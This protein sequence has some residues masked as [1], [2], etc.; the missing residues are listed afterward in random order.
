MS[1][2]ILE[3]ETSKVICELFDKRSIDKLNTE[4]YVA[5]SAY[6]YLCNLNKELNK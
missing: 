1:W 2:I 4:K 6:D 3:K 5:V